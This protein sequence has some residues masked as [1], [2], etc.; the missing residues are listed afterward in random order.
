[1]STPI[2]YT[3]KDSINYNDRPY[4]FLELHGVPITLIR[5]TRKATEE[6]KT[7]SCNRI[8]TGRGPLRVS[9]TFICLYTVYG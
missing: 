6:L 4:I 3:I 8:R 2:L 7:Y 1:M 5:L 9:T